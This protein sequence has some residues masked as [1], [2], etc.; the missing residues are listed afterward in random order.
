MFCCLC[1]YIVYVILFYVLY[2]LYG[3]AQYIYINIEIEQL[4]PYFECA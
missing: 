4:P 1:E 3:Y 2:V